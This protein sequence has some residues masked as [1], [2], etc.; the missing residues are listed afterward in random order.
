MD[1]TAVLQDIAQG[2]VRVVHRDW[3][4]APTIAFPG[5]ACQQDSNKYKHYLGQ[6]ALATC[7]SSSR[8]KIKNKKRSTFWLGF[9][10]LPLLPL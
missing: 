6:A 4:F 8:K 1:F 7:A 10:H 5:F 9:K 3:S 2:W